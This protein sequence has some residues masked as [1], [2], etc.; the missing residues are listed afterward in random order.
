MQNMKRICLAAFFVA[1]TVSACVPLNETFY[2]PYQQPPPAYGPAT[3]RQV[4]RALQR[5]SRLIAAMDGNAAS[6]MYTRNGVWERQSGPVRGRDAIRDAILSAGGAR[7]LSNDMIMNN[8]AYNGPAIVQ[9]GEFRQ[10]VRLANGKTV[11][12]LGHFEAT[13]VQGP[14]GEWLIDRMVTRAEK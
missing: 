1:L 7:V 14:N 4:Q 10:T 5:Y 13:W 2:N 12:V 3:E 6:E 9:T 8:M 11:N